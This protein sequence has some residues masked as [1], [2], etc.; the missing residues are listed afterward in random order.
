MLLSRVQFYQKYG[1]VPTYMREIFKNY[2]YHAFVVIIK[3][4]NLKLARFNSDVG[5]SDRVAVVDVDWA[6]HSLAD[7]ADNFAVCHHS[8]GSCSTEIKFN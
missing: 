5:D 7:L 3:S 6:A 2:V 8:F 4:A 1:Q